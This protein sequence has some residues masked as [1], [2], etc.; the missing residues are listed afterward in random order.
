MKTKKN[1]KIEY[2]QRN[3]KKC[4]YALEIQLIFDYDNERTTIKV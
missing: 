3:T 2:M 1:C 4:S